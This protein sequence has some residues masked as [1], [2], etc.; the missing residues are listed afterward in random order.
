LTFDNQVLRVF[1][2]EENATAFV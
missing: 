2:L 1:P